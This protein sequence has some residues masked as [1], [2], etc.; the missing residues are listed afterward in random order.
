MIDTSTLTASNGGIAKNNCG[1]DTDRNTIKHDTKSH[2]VQ[3]GK[4]RGPDARKAPNVGGLA[5]EPKVCFVFTPSGR[6]PARP[7]AL[8]LQSVRHGKRK[9]E[10]NSA[11]SQD[12]KSLATQK[13]TTSHDVFSS[14]F[15][16]LCLVELH[17]AWF[18]PLAHKPWANF[19]LGKIHGFARVQ[20]HNIKWFPSG[21]T[22]SNFFPTS[23]QHQ[24][25]KQESSVG[26]VPESASLSQQ[27]FAIHQV[28][29]ELVRRSRPSTSA[30][31][32]LSILS[33]E[34]PR[35]A[36]TSFG[37]HSTLKIR[38][39][40]V[41]LLRP[42]KTMWNTP[43]NLENTQGPKVVWF[44]LYEP[45]CRFLFSLEIALFKNHELWCDAL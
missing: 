9:K 18:C 24:D 37:V 39:T 20:P 16:P 3:L 32:L 43:Q 7:S 10:K 22:P 38:P 33:A 13:A 1:T 31:D 34:C 11:H 30:V 23:C 28:S 42:T 35:I 4:E 27:R 14:F 29:L 21:V 25:L 44:L 15:A 6:T 2:T 40:S 8:L 17:V 19:L 45:T 12:K 5:P 41:A 26:I 36:A